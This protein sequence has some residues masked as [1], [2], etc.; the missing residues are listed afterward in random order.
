MPQF[1]ATAT[2]E[3]IVETFGDQ[4]Q[5]RTFV[6]SITIPLARASPGHIVIASRT[7]AKVEPLLSA[8]CESSVKTNTYVQV[9]FS[10]RDSVCRA[11]PEILDAT[12]SRIDV[13][14]N[15]AGNIGMKEYTVDKL[16]P[17][18]VNLTSHGYHISPFRFL[19]HNFFDSKIYDPWAACPRGC[20]RIGSSQFAVHPSSNLDTNLGSHLV[21]DD[22]DDIF[23]IAKRNTGR[24]FISA[25]LITAAIDPDITARAP[26]YLTNIQIN[27]LALHATDPQMG[28]KAVET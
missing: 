13:L 22:H 4:V 25:T 1:D 27:E 2:S 20:R 11:A 17:R 10:N 12:G 24:G 9:D 26:A 8:L 3:Q 16:A 5:D 19:N 7:P 23:E 28:R 14:I 18:V 15:S 21:I 6:S